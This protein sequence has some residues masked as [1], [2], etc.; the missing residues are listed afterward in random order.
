VGPRDDAVA[1][2]V[3][4]RVMRVPHRVGVRIGRRDL[5]DGRFAL[6]DLAVADVDE[7]V[8]G[9]RFCRVPDELAGDSRAMTYAKTAGPDNIAIGRDRLAGTEGGQG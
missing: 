2:Q 4:E 9:P 1:L 6:D 5:G 8:P 3:G 7:S